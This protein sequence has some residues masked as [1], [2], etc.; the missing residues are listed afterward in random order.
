MA[1]RHHLVVVVILV[2][3]VSI[4]DV[5][6][7]SVGPPEKT[8][9]NNIRRLPILPIRGGDEGANEGD[10]RQQRSSSTFSWSTLVT[11]NP[12]TILP[13]LVEKG[14][15]VLGKKMQDQI[16][17]VSELMDC[18]V[19]KLNMYEKRIEIRNFIVSLPDKSPSLRVGRISVQWDTLTRPCLEIEVE[20]ID[21][22]IE[23]VNLFLTKTNW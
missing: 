8:P 4:N 21:V 13:L 19:A 7:T 1:M 23:F 14:G 17:K 11:V 20:D 15:F 10:S 3:F 22:L 16:R 12:K 5:V 18:D 9:Q 2:L 6:G